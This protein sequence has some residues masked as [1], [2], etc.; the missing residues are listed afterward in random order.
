MCVYVQTAAAGVAA[1][2]SRHAGQLGRKS[3]GLQALLKAH[4]LQVSGTGNNCSMFCTKVGASAFGASNH[5]R[6][7][8]CT[9]V[10]GRGMRHYAATLL[11]Q[12]VSAL[13]DASCL[14]DALA[15]RV[16]EQHE[17]LDVLTGRSRDG[18]T[19][20]YTQVFDV[21]TFTEEWCVLVLAHPF[22]GD[23]LTCEILG[24]LWGEERVCMRP[25]IS[26]LWR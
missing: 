9:D 24:T 14:P 3:K 11:S 20:A 2:F 13:P 16:R 19:T 1:T 25:N 10:D 6:D 23:A 12:Q 7:A 21:L 18:Q 15:A 17:L 4:H 22:D 8:M 26:L 5:M